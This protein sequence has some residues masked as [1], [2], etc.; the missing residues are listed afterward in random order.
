MPLPS[1]RKQETKGEFMTRCMTQLADKGEFKDA[2]QRAAVC[3][4]QVTRKKKK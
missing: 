1:P 2:K 3:Y 4:S